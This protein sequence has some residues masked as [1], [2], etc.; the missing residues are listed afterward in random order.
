M[1]KVE[2]FTRKTKIAY[3]QL[4][5]AKNLES[6]TKYELNQHLPKVRESK[7]CEKL[8]FENR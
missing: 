8:Y 6:R 4:D 5:V 1:Q 2:H 7:E 3:T